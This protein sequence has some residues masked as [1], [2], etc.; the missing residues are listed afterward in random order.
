[1]YR[2]VEHRASGPG[3]EAAGIDHAIAVA[4]FSSE[5]RK[6]VQTPD[7][8]CISQLLSFLQHLKNEKGE[9]KLRGKFP[10]FFG[11]DDARRLELFIKKTSTFR[12]P[13]AQRR[14]AWTVEKAKHVAGTL[15]EAWEGT[16]NTTPIQPSPQEQQPQYQQHQQG[17]EEQHR[18]QERRRN[19][20]QE[21]GFQRNRT[22]AYAPL[23]IFLATDSEAL[24]PLFV[25]FLRPFGHVVY[26]KGRV[27]HL[28]KGKAGD[29]S[30]RLPTVAEFYLLSKASVLVS[31]KKRTSS[32]QRCAALYGNGTLIGRGG[33]GPC[34]FAIEHMA[35]PRHEAMQELARRLERGP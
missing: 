20:E 4:A 2:C 8:V 1:M 30:M 18:A 21:G 35:R 12:I 10:L 15:R 32:F 14:S 34:G 26:S 29:E 3:C 24:R 31:Y 13:N 27:V 7:W 5:L 19:Q 9:D 11:P 33:R 23:S 6:F 25:E 28:A 22:N 17:D 16:S